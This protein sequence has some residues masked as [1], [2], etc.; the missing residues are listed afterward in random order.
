M[1]ALPRER[2]ISQYHHGG[3]GGCHLRWQHMPPFTIPHSFLLPY[4]F[5]INHHVSQGQTGNE[6]SQSCLN[7]CVCERETKGNEQDAGMMV[8]SNIDV[9]TS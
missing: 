9:K 2:P 8:V 6:S 7:L 3:T 1:R 4:T 5:P